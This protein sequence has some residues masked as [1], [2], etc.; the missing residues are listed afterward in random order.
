MKKGK[1]ARSHSDWFLRLITHSSCV[2]LVARDASP[3]SFLSLFLFLSFF[4]LVPCHTRL[5][6]SDLTRILP[7]RRTN[8]PIPAKMPDVGVR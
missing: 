3:H 4:A 2:G 8:A 5:V 6:R 7:N 1:S